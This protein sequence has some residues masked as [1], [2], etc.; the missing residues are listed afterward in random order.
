MTMTM[1][2]DANSIVHLGLVDIF[3]DPTFNCRGS[4]APIDVAD[5]ARDIEE[6]GL[7]QPIVVKPI[8]DR[9]Y[10][11]KA[12]S[13]HRRYKAFQVL[14][15]ETIPCIINEEISDSQA[16]ILNLGENLHRKDLNILQEANALERLKMEGFSVAEVSESLG[17]S[18]TWVNIRYMLLEL[19]EIIREAAA[20]GFI[21]QRHIIDLHK[22]GD[23]KKQVNA[24]KKIKAA[25]LRGEK[26]PNLRK[27]KKRNLTKA[28][29]R[30]RDDVFWMQNHIQES[31]GNNFGTRCLAWAAGE[32]NDF[33]LFKDIDQIAVAAEIPYRIP[34]E[35]GEIS[36]EG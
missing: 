3:A 10:K 36:Y 2:K 17:R 11:Y 8:E 25:R 23:Y 27:G 22:L 35:L 32:I 26:P 6:H 14:K 29:T 20:A 34:Y 4:I 18:S 33:D 19:P 5:L 16:L 1:T 30:D 21:S 28:K 31:I 9:K 24:A 12:I 7:Q 13:G 15:R